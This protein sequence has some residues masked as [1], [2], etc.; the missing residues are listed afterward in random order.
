M[1]DTIDGVDIYGSVT[2]YR[3]ATGPQRIAAALFN[4][5]D[6]PDQPLSAATVNAMIDGDFST[7]VHDCSGPIADFQAS[8]VN[9]GV[10]GYFTLPRR[11][12]DYLPADVFDG[13][14]Y[15]YGQADG[16]LNSDI[17]SRLYAEWP[18]WDKE[19]DSIWC[20][21]N[22]LGTV[23]TTGGQVSRFSMQ[24]GFYMKFLV[25]ESAGH[26]LGRIWHGYS[27]DYPSPEPGGVFPAN[28]APP[29]LPDV[30]TG[31]G[32]R[33]GYGDGVDP[34]G[35]FDGANQHGDIT[36][37][38]DWFNVFHRSA[39]GWYPRSPTQVRA[40]TLSTYVPEPG[41]GTYDPELWALGDTINFTQ[42]VLNGTEHG[43]E[44]PLPTP[45]WSYWLEYRYGKFRGVYLWL[46]G[47]FDGW[48]DTYLLGRGNP[49]PFGVWV[50]DPYRFIQ[51]RLEAEDP[52]NGA[53]V[54]IQ[55][56]TPGPLQSEAIEFAQKF[57]QGR[58]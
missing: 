18:T 51:F 13:L 33:V 23:G 29:S 30:D 53:F 22:G 11:L 12:H 6:Y 44:I 2:A 4:F 5:P 58:F 9:K 20:I 1:P 17:T 56:A 28:W 27:L 50:T 41:H 39:M 34:M 45:G 25:H 10:V 8:V 48:G 19:V 35:V 16:T 52:G 55:V 31:G 43:L 14:V 57:R 26:G 38:P 15:P 46:S 47:P 40:G 24:K 36:T 54:R 37:V 32:H 42:P 7:W 3:Q 21:C 49:L